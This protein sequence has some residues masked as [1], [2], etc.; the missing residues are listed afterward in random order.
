MPSSNTKNATCLE[1]RL[2]LYKRR[3]KYLLNDNVVL[4]VMVVVV[5]AVVVVVVLKK[6]SNMK[7]EFPNKIIPAN[8]YF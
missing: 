1:T 2:L 6:E 5:V 4:A 7:V 3:Y 8:P